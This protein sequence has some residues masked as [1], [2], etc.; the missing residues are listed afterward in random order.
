MLTRLPETRPPTLLP[1]TA[2]FADAASVRLRVS[3]LCSRRAPGLDTLLERSAGLDAPYRIVSVVSSDR[4]CAEGRRLV[5]RGTAFRVRDIRAFY[6]D[7]GA[8]VTDREVRRE[9][10]RLLLEALA[11][12]RPDVVLLCGYLY[13]VT[14]VILDAFPGRVLNIHHADLA[15][16]GRDGRPRYPGLRAVRDALLAGEPATRS[17]V[18]LATPRVDEGPIVARSEPFPVLPALR[19]RLGGRPSPELEAYA[20]AHREW[21]MEASWGPLLHR[22]LEAVAAGRTTPAAPAVEAGK[23]S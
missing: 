16:R 2:G 14:S 22:A 20:H 18:H 8:P 23:G 4:R 6:E 5:G 3:I 13:V 17:T 12:D 10:D 9:Y 21:M 15:V 7:R 19:A 11:G 1:R